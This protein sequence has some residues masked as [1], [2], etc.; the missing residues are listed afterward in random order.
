MASQNALKDTSLYLKDT[1]SFFSL[2]IPLHSLFFSFLN[3]LKDT[4]LCLKDPSLFF[5]LLV[6]LIIFI[7]SKFYF[8]FLITATNSL[9][10]KVIFLPPFIGPDKDFQNYW[11]GF[12]IVEDVVSFTNSTFYLFNSNIWISSVEK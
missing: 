6:I 4:S 3:D 7:R 5:H 10:F 12:V 2:K 11:I 8:T 9:Y 1:T